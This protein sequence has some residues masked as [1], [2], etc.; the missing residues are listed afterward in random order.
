MMSI[1]AVNPGRWPGLLLKRP[2]GAVDYTQAGQGWHSPIY[3]SLRAKQLNCM[4]QL[5]CE[6]RGQ[7]LQKRGISRPTRQ[8]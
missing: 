7:R 6:S 2:F 1:I 3:A 4:S 8:Q 5:G